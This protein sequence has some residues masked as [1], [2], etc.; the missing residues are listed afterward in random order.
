VRR[1]A[2]CALL[3][4]ACGSPPGESARALARNAGFDA[5]AAV[6]ADSAFAD[7]VL[8]AAE[9]MG[10]ARELRP[11][12]LSAPVRDANEIRLAL[13]AYSGGS[14]IDELFAERDSVN[15]RW[16]DRVR[17]PLHVWIQSAPPDA[18]EATFPRAVEE[19][20][21]PWTAVGIPVAFLFTED[22]ARADIHVTW[23]TRYESRTTGRTRWVHD[24]HGWI[25]AASI[26]LARE[27]PDGMP[28][29]RRSI[30]AIAR[31]EVG[32]LLGLGHSTSA[33]HIMSADVRVTELSEADRATVRLVYLLPPGSVR[34]PR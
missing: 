11:S 9:D 34:A 2:V 25:T 15:Y 23:V 19:A 27:Q 14:Y 30:Q 6:L 32:H 18:S 21:L 24:Q 3:A 8:R 17:E 5:A 26:E 28:L 12:T 10:T 22:S 1:T 20:F 16:P 31:H 7:S 29:D 13:Q 33:E 4:L